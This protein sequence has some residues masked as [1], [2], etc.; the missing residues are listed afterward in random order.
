MDRRLVL[1]FAVLCACGPDRGA[2]SECDEMCDVLVLDCGY[3]AFP[4]F[5]SCVQGCTYNAD[6]G[7]DI[8]GELA[9]VQASECDT[10][11]IVEC[12]HEYGLVE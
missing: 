4:S 10:F 2:K 3:E 1:I 6:Q 11:A 9:C 8:A 12:E 5:D 7:A